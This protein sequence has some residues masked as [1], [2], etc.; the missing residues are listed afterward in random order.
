MSE[1]RR[2]FHPWC[3][4]TT[5]VAMIAVGEKRGGGRWEVKCSDGVRDE[6]I[7][8]VIRIPYSSTVLLLKLAHAAA[9]LRRLCKLCKLAVLAY[10]AH[11]TVLSIPGSREPSI[12]DTLK[13]LCLLAGVTSSILMAALAP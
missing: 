3:V 7:G 5:E 12:P 1:T 10:E 6:L 4:G 2:L 13:Q 8:K 9:E 11:C